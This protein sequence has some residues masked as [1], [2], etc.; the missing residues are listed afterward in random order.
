VTGPRPADELLRGRT[1]VLYAR[2]W[3]IEITVRPGVNLPVSRAALARLAASTLTSAGAPS[4]ASLGLIFSDYVEL[5]DLNRE[6]MGRSGPTD[7]LSFPLL[8][9]SAYL[10]HPGRPAPRAAGARRSS[11]GREPPDAGHAAPAFALPPGT[12]P[13]LGDVV[14]SVERAQLQAEQGR[15]GQTGDRRWEPADEIRLLVVHGILHICGWDHA[16]AEEMHAMHA[17]E[18]RLVGLS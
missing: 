3:R 17:L 18:R 5:A 7:V 11:P 10:P 1:S 9:P 12:R 13:H 6:A 4:P 14:I 8:P 15:G 16:E 2:P